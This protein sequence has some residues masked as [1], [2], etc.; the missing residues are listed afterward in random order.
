MGMIT[1]MKS[2]KKRYT[3]LVAG[4]SGQRMLTDIPKQFIPVGGKPVLMRTICKFKEF[5]P[6]IEIIVVLPEPFGPTIAV[7]LPAPIERLM[8]LSTTALPNCFF[9]LIIS[10]K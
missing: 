2:I 10:I 4:G 5:D 8:L 1:A 9:R 6:K 3:I 7:T